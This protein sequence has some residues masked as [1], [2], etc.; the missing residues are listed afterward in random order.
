MSAKIHKSN[1]ARQQAY[2]DRQYVKKQE[3]RQVAVHKLGFHEGRTVG[4]HPHLPVKGCP[5][6][7]VTQNRKIVTLTP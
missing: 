1:V 2:R 6:C 4:G 3:A 5:L 7:T